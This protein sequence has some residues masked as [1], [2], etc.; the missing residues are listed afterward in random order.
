MKREQQRA[1]SKR[2]SDSEKRFKKSAFGPLRIKSASINKLTSKFYSDQ[3]KSGRLYNAHRP[4][5]STLAVRMGPSSKLTGNCESASR[6]FPRSLPGHFAHILS[7][8]VEFRAKRGAD[9][10]PEHRDHCSRVLHCHGTS[11]SILLDALFAPHFTSP[12][13]TTL[14]FTPPPPNQPTPL[15]P[16]SLRFFTPQGAT[17]RINL[18]GKNTQ[19]LLKKCVSKKQT[20][21]NKTS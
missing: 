18:Q 1:A 20:R 21:K 16:G 3:V 2:S 4:P 11:G 15:P 14:T 10:E 19:S 17:I 5:R 12:D 8:R 6:C 13:V 9:G 7:F